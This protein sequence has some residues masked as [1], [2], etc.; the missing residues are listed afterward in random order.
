MIRPYRRAG[1]CSRRKVKFSAV[2]KVKFRLAK[3]VTLWRGA[4]R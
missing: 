3:N 2:R 4:P 1:A